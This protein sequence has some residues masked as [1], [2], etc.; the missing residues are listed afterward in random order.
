MESREPQDFIA[1]VLLGS[2]SLYVAYKLGQHFPKITT[3]CWKLIG[4]ALGWC[5]LNVALYLVASYAV[6]RDAQKWWSHGLGWHGIFIL[7]ALQCA[8]VLT[9]F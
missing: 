2:V 6:Y 8:F 1:T 5:A 3:P 9:M 7:S 4:L